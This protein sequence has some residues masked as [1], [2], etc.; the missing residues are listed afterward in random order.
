MSYVHEFSMSQWVL[1][2]EA[3]KKSAKNQKFE[4]LFAHQLF[5]LFNQGTI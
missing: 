3:D 2:S 5:T 1:G 4:N